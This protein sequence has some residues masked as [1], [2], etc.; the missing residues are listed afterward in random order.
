MTKKNGLP[1]TILLFCLFIFF[2]Q[3]SGEYKAF[4]SIDQS[5]IKKTQAIQSGERLEF[6]INWMG[7]NAG[8]AVMEVGPPMVI[9]DS[10]AFPITSTARSNDFISRFF[11]V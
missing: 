4:S 9:G 3:L 11:P 10:K 5:E 8:K 6:S 2:T 7:I 1:R